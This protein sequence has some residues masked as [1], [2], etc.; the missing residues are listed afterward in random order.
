MK[1]DR[2]GW[3]GGWNGGNYICVSTA[4]GLSCHRYEDNLAADE[5][6]LGDSAFLYWA[7]VASVV[8]PVVYILAVVHAVLWGL[9]SAIVGSLVYTCICS[10]ASIH[11]LYY[12]QA[13]ILGMVYITGIGCGMITRAITLERALY[14]LFH[15]D[16]YRKSWKLMFAGGLVATLFWVCWYV[17]IIAI[18]QREETIDIIMPRIEPC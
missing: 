11:N 18:W 8:G 3:K 6:D 16:N 4:C 10:Y 12:L 7:W 17:A 2:G 14:I 15:L 5:F 9:P 1:K 13:A